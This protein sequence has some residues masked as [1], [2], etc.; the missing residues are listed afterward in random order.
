LDFSHRFV[1]GGDLAS[2]SSPLIE[3]KG[4]ALNNSRSANVTNWLRKTGFYL[5]EKI[6]LTFPILYTFV[7]AN[8]KLREGE[9]SEFRQSSERNT[10]ERLTRQLDNYF[11]NGRLL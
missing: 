8:I 2:A 6:S 1:A 7:E 10:I 3:T 11:Y 4:S 9:I 5:S